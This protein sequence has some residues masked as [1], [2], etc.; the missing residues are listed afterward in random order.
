MAY[1]YLDC[2]V[3]VNCYFVLVL[4][5]NFK[6]LL[7]Y[8]SLLFLSTLVHHEFL[9]GYVNEYRIAELFVTSSQHIHALSGHEYLIQPHVCTC[10]IY[11]PHS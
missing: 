4:A 1:V 9:S 3:R 7:S 10:S 11:E 8:T 2:T 6:V 5:V